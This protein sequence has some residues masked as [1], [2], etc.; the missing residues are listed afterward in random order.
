MTD[1][2][3]PKTLSDLAN[4]LEDLLPSA[5]VTY[6]A[7]DP[8]G[9][10]VRRAFVHVQIGHPGISHTQTQMAAVSKARRLARQLGV[11]VHITNHAGSFH[12][13]QA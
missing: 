10:Y 3:T 11:P 1:T 5:E 9:A 8:S 2:Q 7:T 6:F 12:I 13:I 4:A